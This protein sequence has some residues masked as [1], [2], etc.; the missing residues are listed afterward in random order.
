V[1][2]STFTLSPCEHSY[3]LNNVQS[4]ALCTLCGQE[5]SPSDVAVLREEYARKVEEWKREGR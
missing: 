2:I 3:R 4:G 1:H 5:A